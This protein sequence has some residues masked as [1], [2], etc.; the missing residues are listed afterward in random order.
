MSTDEPTVVRSCTDGIAEIVL[1]NPTA[2][3]AITR[4][5]YEELC[6]AWRWIEAD[7]EVRVA[8]FTAAGERH[9][10]LGGDLKSLSKQGTLRRPGER[11]TLTWRQAGVTKP[12]IVAVNGTVA[13][14]GLGFVTDGDVVVASRNAKFLDTHVAVG[15][16]CGYGALRLVRLIGSS[17]AI[18]IGLAG[19][20]LTA[21]RAHALG[22]VNELYDDP[23]GAVAATRALATRIVAASPAAVRCTFELQRAMASEVDEAEVL[24]RADRALEH[25]M[26]HPDASEGPAAWLEKRTP[27]WVA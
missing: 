3:N 6:D 11:W 27:R 23:A 1:H 16:I 26:T 19:G 4:G 13:G 5:I 9:F 2:G 18:R 14:G 21:E 10:C 12:V 8:T 17:E 15:Q 25:H 22:L 24:S 20:T 7:P